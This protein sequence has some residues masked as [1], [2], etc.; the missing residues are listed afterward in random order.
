MPDTAMLLAL[1]ALTLS[2]R[3]GF[4]KGE[5]ASLNRIGN[6]FSV[7]GNYPKAMESYLQALKI[8][9][10]INNIDG[11]ARNLGNI[12]PI[13]RYQ[14]DY[15][16]ALEYAFKSKDLAEKINNRQ[17]IAIC[18][19]NIGMDYYRLK[20]FDSARLYAQKSYNVAKGIN[21]FRAM[22]PSLSLMGDI[23]L[24]TGQNIL[25]L[26]YYRLSIPYLKKS[27]IDLVLSRTF[28]GI[29]KVFEKIGQNDSSLFYAKQSLIISQEKNL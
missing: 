21:Y 20:I 28:L 16:Q 18:F 3:I 1:E 23:C 15:R 25:A 26:E 14:G 12:G 7:L 8:N 13:Y 11:I 29:A 27:E 22:G 4:K 9:E 6:A 19:S 5:A 10:K 2:K 17:S 24:E